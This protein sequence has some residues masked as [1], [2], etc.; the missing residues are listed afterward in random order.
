MTD[1]SPQTQ[2]EIINQAF[3]HEFERFL[4]LIDNRTL[5]LEQALAEQRA[6]A[7]FRTRHLGKKSALAAAKKLI[8]RVA[9]EE[10]ASFGQQ[11]QSTE[12]RLDR[13]LGEVE[14]SLTEIIHEQ[15]TAR[16]SI[17]ITLPGRRPRTGHRHPITLLRERLEDVF[18]SLGYAIEDEGRAV[19]KFY[20]A[21]AS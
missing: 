10:R 19:I 9:P 2:L 11:V 15:R 8:G 13:L 14:R 12:Q 17:D 6:V 16:E 20:R 21:Q 7:E 1:Q 5:D 3:D 18:V 4:P